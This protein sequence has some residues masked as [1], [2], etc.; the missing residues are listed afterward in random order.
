VIKDGWYFT[1]DIAQMDEDGFITITDRLSRFSKIGGEMV[2]HVRVEEAI[3]KV[4]NSSEQIAVVASVPDEKKGEKLV[5]FYTKDIDIPVLRRTSE[6]LRITSKNTETNSIFHRISSQNLPMLPTIE[7][8]KLNRE[9]IQT[10]PL[11]P[12]KKSLKR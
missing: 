6:K 9:R 4:L 1:G 3:H 12:Y 7:S 10:Q 2:P 5:V 8:L 11:K